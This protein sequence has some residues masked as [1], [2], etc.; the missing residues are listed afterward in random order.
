MVID[1][2]LGDRHRQNQCLFLRAI[3]CL[4]LH[5]QKNGSILWCTAGLLYKYHEV[6]LAIE[7]HASWSLSYSRMVWSRILF[8][9]NACSWLGN[10]E[11]SRFDASFWYLRL[12]LRRS[13]VQYTLLSCKFSIPRLTRECS[14]DT[15]PQSTLQEVDP[16]WGLSWVLLVSLLSAGHSGLVMVSA[17]PFHD[18]DY[19]QRF[20]DHTLGHQ[21]HHAGWNQHCLKL[22]RHPVLA[23]WCWS[24]CHVFVRWWRRAGWHCEALS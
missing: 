3:P 8:K 14:S 7:L 9:H 22:F 2:T 20:A 5:S 1:P 4:N 18:P 12:S 11:H 17:R 6:S 10:L 21:W 23:H 16:C 19:G 13:W 15:S 24:L